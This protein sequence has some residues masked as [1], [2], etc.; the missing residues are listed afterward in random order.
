MGMDLS[1]TRMLLWRLSQKSYSTEFLTIFRCFLS[2]QAHTPFSFFVDFQN[3]EA[4]VDNLASVIPLKNLSSSCN[5]LQLPWDVVTYPQI[6]GASNRC[7]LRSH[8]WR[9]WWLWWIQFTSNAQNITTLQG[10]CAP[11]L[12]W[13]RKQGPT[14]SFLLSTPS[15]LAGWCDVENTHESTAQDI[16]IVF[17]EVL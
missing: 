15:S 7:C 4:N 3:S 10:H 8:S 17:L 11:C 14:P 1:G 5:R 2:L 12:G 6:V 16:V 9:E 13:R